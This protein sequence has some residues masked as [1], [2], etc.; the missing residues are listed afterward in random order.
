MS[1][2]LDALKKSEKKR[3]TAEVPNLHTVHGEGPPPRKRRPL[4]PYL[5]IAV[6]LLNA[7]VLIWY[8]FFREEPQVAAVVIE[9]GPARDAESAPLAP[10]PP[11]VPAPEPV[12]PSPEPA[13]EPVSAT[14][15]ATVVREVAPPP[16]PVPPPRPEP[17]PAPV[18]EAEAAQVAAP[19]PPPVESRPEVSV[20]APVPEPVSPP[21][22][23][24]VGPPPVLELEDLPGDVRGRVPEMTIS[25]Y[26]YSATPA[27]R[28]VRINNRIL[29]EG[30]YLD[31]G[32]RLEE[33]APK[34]LIFTFEGFRF[35]VPKEM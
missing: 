31:V 9:P 25:V 2:I 11:A 21:Q 20:A 26:A 18:R 15:P 27:S 24:E 13:P 10:A 30:G 32:L 12:I 14:A 19:P 8:V 16:A 22:P 6:L 33:I 35:R 1:F 3:E 29:R 28:L 4:W 7:G 34:E 17:A 23:I 5:L